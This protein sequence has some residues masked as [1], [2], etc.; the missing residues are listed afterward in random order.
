ME[1]RLDKIEIGYNLLQLGKNKLAKITKLDKIIKILDNRIN[2][3]KLA[4]WKNRKLVPI[5]KLDKISKMLE[6]RQIPQNYQ[7]GK[8]SKLVKITKSDKISKI[9]ENRLNWT[10]L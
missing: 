4:N 9:L 5:T 6:N 1:N 2:W 8:N 3:R 10:K 7:I